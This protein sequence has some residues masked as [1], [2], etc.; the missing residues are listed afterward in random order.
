MKRLYGLLV[1]ALLISSPVKS[2]TDSLYNVNTILGIPEIFNS[3]FFVDKDTGWIAGSYGTLLR[4]SDGGCTWEHRDLL[5]NQDLLQ[6]NFKDSEFGWVFSKDSLLYTTDGGD[7]WLGIN[8]P[9]YLNSVFMK[10]IDN[11]WIGRGNTLYNTTDGGQTWSL[12][13][14]YTINSIHFSD[15]LNGWGVGSYIIRTTNGGQTFT[16]YS[17]SL[18]YDACYLSEDTIWTVG[19]AGT[20]LKIT[21]SPWNYEYQMSNS[22]NTLRNIDF[23]R[24]LSCGYCVGLNAT[25]RYTTNQGEEWI[26]KSYPYPGNFYSV[27]VNSPDNV[28]IV[29]EEAILTNH[30]GVFDL[31][32]HDTTIIVGT[33][34]DVTCNARAIPAPLYELIQAPANMTIDGSTGRI[35]WTPLGTGDFSAVIKTE[36]E[37]GSLLDTLNIHVI[38]VSAVGELPDVASDFILSSFPNPFNPLTN[39]SFEVSVASDITIKLFDVL[40][41]EL[42]TLLDNKEMTVGKYTITWNAQNYP[43]GIYICTL[44]SGKFKK[45]TKLLLIK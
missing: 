28:W 21:V 39:I 34:L 22:S 5:P 43:S 8:T 25:I 9:G 4:T 6:I 1:I 27:Q 10:S 45:T 31:D 23:N 17:S 37:F 13:L 26:A 33:A 15:D 3:V 2:Q 12:Q 35:R 40:G 11:I 38:P 32:V 20:I 36:N 16:G 19:E 41:N 42:C 24:D 7:I 18:L 44:I 14:Y 30:I 29:G